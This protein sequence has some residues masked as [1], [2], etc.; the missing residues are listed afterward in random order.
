M[1]FKSKR[2]RKTQTCILVSDAEFAKGA[3]GFTADDL[4]LIDY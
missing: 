4:G 1:I 2:H 3:K